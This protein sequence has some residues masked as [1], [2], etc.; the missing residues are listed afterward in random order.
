MSRL[1]SPLILPYCCKVSLIYASILS[2]FRG[3]DYRKGRQE[4]VFGCG[5]DS[6]RK[7]GRAELVSGCLEDLLRIFFFHCLN[8]DSNPAGN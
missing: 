8:V 5:R 4:A 3:E 6:A 7:A 2:L 1:S